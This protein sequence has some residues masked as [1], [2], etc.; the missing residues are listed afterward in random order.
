MTSFGL[1]LEIFGSVNYDYGISVI[2]LGVAGFLATLA[3]E[4]SM[5]IWSTC[6][7]ILYA[8]AAANVIALI[9]S[10]CLSSIH[11]DPIN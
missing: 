8:S 10:L 9:A 2:G 3:F 1:C 11:F 5:M 4:W 7:P 6:T